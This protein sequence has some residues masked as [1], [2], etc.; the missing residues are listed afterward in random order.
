MIATHCLGRILSRRSVLLAFFFVV[1]SAATSLAQTYTSGSG[2]HNTLMSSAQTGT[3]TATFDAVPSVSPENGVMGLSK[4]SATAFSGIACIARFNPSG[5]IDAYNGTAYAAAATIHYSAGVTY[6]FRLVVNPTARTYSA[7]VTPAGGSELTVGL[8][9]GFRTTATSLDTWTFD[10]DPTVTA[11]LTVSNLTILGNSVVAAPAFSP[12]GGTYSSAQNVTITSAT[13]GATIHY[14][15]DGSTPTSTTGNLYSGPVNISSTG[16]LKAIASETGFIDSPVTSAAYTISSVVQIAAPTGLVSTGK[17]DTTVSLSWTASTTSTVI[18]YN[19]NIGNAL[20]GTTASTSF[21]VTG[22]TASTGYSFN[23]TA[24]DASANESGPSNTVS[25]TTNASN[26]G[27]GTLTGTSGNGFHA[28]AL[29]TAQTG[30]FTT[31]FD[32]TPSVSPENSVI[33]LSKGAATAYTGLSCIA[34][35]NPTGQ[36]D[37]YNAT[38]YAAAASINYSAGVSYHFRMVVNVAAHSY[39][40]YVT[41][42]GGSELTVGLNYGFR[43]A[44]TSLDTWDLDLNATPANCSL[45]VNNLAIAGSLQAAAPAFSPGGGAYS[46]AQNVAISTTT[47]GAS[48]RY[49]IDG[50]TPSETAGTLYSG[51]INIGSTTTL[52]AIA[53][54]NGFADSAV[55]SATYTI[56]SQ[57][58]VA[59]PAFSP[60]P[61]TYSSAQSVAISTTTGGATIH[62]TIDGSTPTSTTGTVYTAPVSISGTTT[63][64]AIA[65]E[66]GFTD[67][68]VTS[69]VYTITVATGGAWVGTF[70]GF[71]GAAWSAAWGVAAPPQADSGSPPGA[72]SPDCF[73]FVAPYT[74]PNGGITISTDKGPSGHAAAITYYGANSSAFSC[75]CG[76]AKGGAQFYEELQDTRNTANVG[77]NIGNNPGAGRPDLANARVLYLKYYVKFPVGFDF[78]K[79]GKL[80][81]FFGGTEGDESGFNTGPNSFSTRY[82][83]RGTNGEVYEYDPAMPSGAAGND[84]GAGNWHWQADGQWH[85]IEQSIS[86]TAG[87]ITVWYDGVQVYASGPGVMKGFSSTTPFGGIIFSTFYGG[88]DSSWGPKTNTTAE[89]AD[90]TIDTKF[91]P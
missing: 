81:G 29:P 15:T 20:I 48:I 86:I 71:P 11:S 17:T 24:F 53:Y 18:G 30:T 51:P 40:V 44:A 80:P 82:M 66:S 90:F 88:H 52:K 38:A 2:F 63:L 6:H 74:P 1:A 72:R 61:G 43:A 22:L 50:S 70:D 9:Y 46:S 21:T 62:Y 41:P 19:V 42:A 75:S 85:S 65:F 7:Y 79:A 57:Q 27:G 8:N 16:T 12:G 49:T 56:G 54:E 69:G 77:Q 91:I 55:T 68:P 67:S 35:F 36:I 83:W 78:G 64:K 32:A 25:V 4:G 58:Q 73:G 26:G 33:G 23:V 59:A 10:V 47:S 14:T 28:L 13:G 84:L 87:S 45:T 89:W 37:A 39:S 60:A 34:R 76:S 5:D 3:F 31:T